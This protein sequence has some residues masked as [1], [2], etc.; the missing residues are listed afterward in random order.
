MEELQK[1]L[2]E[3]E[4]L[5]FQYDAICGLVYIL[6]DSISQN[7]EILTEQYS[8]GCFYI[9]N[10]MMEF[11]TDLQK[12]LEDFFTALSNIKENGI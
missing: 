1:K 4:K 7:E 11:Q 3:L 5:C 6:K 8:I 9:S 10:I 2:R 12:L